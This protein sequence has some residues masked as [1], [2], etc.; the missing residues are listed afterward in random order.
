MTDLR[1]FD[2]STIPTDPFRA[3]VY[4]TDQRLHEIDMYASHAA[5]GIPHD[6]AADLLSAVGI[7]LDPLPD[8]IAQAIEAHYEPLL[9][10]IEGEQERRL[11]LRMRC[12]DCNVNTG[13]IGQ[14]P[15]DC[16][17]ELWHAV[18]PG[19][20]GMLCLACLARRLDAAGLAWPWSIGPDEIAA[21]MEWEDAMDVSRKYATP[22][23]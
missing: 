18:V 23:T 17:D 16:P 19:G 20:R 15:Y 12:L 5:H 2:L 6:I 7:Q 22:P 1:L 8:D 3:L 9:D 10:A 14:Y 11:D 21:E 13:D 4:L